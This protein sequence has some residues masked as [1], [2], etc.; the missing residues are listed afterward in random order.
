MSKQ[1]KTI[2]I[3]IH[4]G[5]AKCCSTSVQHLIDNAAKELME[6]EIKKHQKLTHIRI[7]C[8]V[9]PQGLLAAQFNYAKQ[10]EQ[11][12]KRFFND[13][14]EHIKHAA[15]T[16][17]LLG[18]LGV[19]E[20]PPSEEFYESLISR[21]KLLHK[22]C[23]K[24]DQKITFI[25]SSESLSPTN[26]NNGNRRYAEIVRRLDSH[27]ARNLEINLT[28]LVREPESLAKSLMRQNWSSDENINEFV[29]KISAHDRSYPLEIIN[30]RSHINDLKNL[31]DSTNNI[32]LNCLCIKSE[33]IIASTKA[34]YALLSFLFRLTKNDPLLKC[35]NKL[36]R[37]N[38]SK[39][40]DLLAKKL[41]NYGIS[42]SSIKS[43]LSKSSISESEKIAEEIALFVKVL[44]QDLGTPPE[45]IKNKM[46]SMA[47]SFQ[48]K[49]L[50]KSML[51]I[52]EY[53]Y[54]AIKKTNLS[55]EWEA[56]R[57][58]NKQLRKTFD[59]LNE[60][61]KKIDSIVFL[62]INEKK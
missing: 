29:Q 32:S 53:F 54:Q 46:F 33:S 31:S 3:S 21:L 13:N 40:E 10:V 16:V 61:Y 49:K 43:G 62:Q 30:T 19:H 6:H 22:L 27:L 26:L 9:N 8:G 12:L 20:N 36:T 28:L 42:L 44:I 60:Y 1:L 57:S 5:L 15:D 7:F 4:A 24:L 2:C 56:A 59:S 11:L 38:Q 35:C 17:S 18:T 39:P 14:Q 45:V 50:V 23:T 51:P 48:Y 34:R 25:L 52:H 41:S 58:P 37:S 55:K 47:D